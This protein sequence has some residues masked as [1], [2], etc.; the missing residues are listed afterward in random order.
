MRVLK[1][2]NTVS[3]IKREDLF[4]LN[5]DDITQHNRRS[6]RALDKVYKIDVVLHIKDIPF[7][8]NGLNLFYM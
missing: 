3:E 4:G 1:T 5:L 2:M 8:I 6:V 7:I